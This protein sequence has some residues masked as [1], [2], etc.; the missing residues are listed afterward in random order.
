MMYVGLGSWTR[1]IAGEGS[2]LSV[3]PTPMSAACVAGQSGVSSISPWSCIFAAWAHRRPL[4]GAP[5][6]LNIENSSLN[7]GNSCVATWLHPCAGLAIREMASASYW[8]VLHERAQLVECTVLGMV[9]QVGTED[10]ACAC[11]APTVRPGT[12]SIKFCMLR[13]CV[14]GVG[15]TQ[16]Q[17][18][19]C[20]GQRKLFVVEGAIQ[21]IDCCIAASGSECTSH[22]AARERAR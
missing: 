3:L 1:W 14:L 20:R 16:R 19:A 5:L 18:D 13:R 10:G 11:L 2:L 12:T 22:G 7:I 17:H 8:R 21:N 4:I 6:Y 9:A 15:N